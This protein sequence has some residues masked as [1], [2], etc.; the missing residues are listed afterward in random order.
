MAPE[1]LGYVSEIG[2]VRKQYANSVRIFKTYIFTDLKRTRI[3]RSAKPLL[4]LLLRYFSETP[5]F[6]ENYL[7]MRNTADVT[8]G[9][10]IADR[11]LSQV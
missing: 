5:T 6:Y 8:G 3:G 11:S 1:L 9:K 4:R 7:T 2:L 10:P